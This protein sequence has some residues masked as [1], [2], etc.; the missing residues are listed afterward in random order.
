MMACYTKLVVVNHGMPYGASGCES[1]CAIL[2]RV[3]V[4]HGV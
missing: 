3:V 2:I 1:W 4:S